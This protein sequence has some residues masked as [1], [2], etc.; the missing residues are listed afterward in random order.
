M[1]STDVLVI[2]AGAAGLVAAGALT[3]AGHHVTILE[4][5]HRIGGR[6]HTIYDP[7][8]PVPIELGA[9][10]IHGKPP[11]LWTRIENGAWP[12]LEITAPFLHV[13]D[14][15]VEH[16][17][18]EA[19]DRLLEAMSNAPEQSF[20]DYIERADAPEDARR[21][22]TGYVEGFNA[23]RR[24][25]ISVRSLAQ[26]EDAAA[27]ID[28][29]RS[30]RPTA[31][32]ASLLPLLWSE[33]DRS[34]CRLHLATP[35]ARVEWSRGRVRIT[36]VDGRTFDAPHA[37][38]TLPLG[39]L[40]CGAVQFDREPAIL[41]DA[42]SKLVMGHAA[43]IVMRFRR[44]LWEDRDDLAGAGFLLSDQPF[45]PTWWTSLPARVP[46]ITGWS[47]GPRAESAPHDPAA[48]VDPAIHSLA[49]ILGTTPGAVRAELETWDA[50][51]WSADPYSVGAYSYVGVGGV[52]AQEHFGDPVE[53]TLYF[54]GESV[55]TNGH[56]G[57]VHA[58]LAS[59]LRA[60]HRI[61]G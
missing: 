55:A 40:Q 44:P 15:R 25:L 29:D 28:G 20:R 42:C 5:R 46:V 7:L 45:M 43:R 61:A 50:H 51:N 53:N 14:G 6:I 41:R 34:R 52:P 48:W 56:I 16:A 21:S 30:F 18:W 47:G 10:F 26:A 8:S 19:S 11:E 1:I 13:R 35:I 2:G 17:D 3:R 12:A 54:A 39:V 49:A 58:A 32:Y 9:E 60:A 59:G 31:G 23:A 57:T 37:V 36:S 22:A 24:E 38:V 27:R 4:A 33:L